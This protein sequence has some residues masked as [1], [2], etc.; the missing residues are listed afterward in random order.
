MFGFFALLLWAGSIMCFIAYALAPEDPSNLYLGI[1]LAIVVFLTGLVTFY[2]NQKSDAIMDSFKNF[3]PPKAT[4]IR[5]GEKREI[6][7]RLLV[8]GDIVLIKD[9]CKIPADV[10]IIECTEMKVD[11]SSLTGESD[12]LQ[13]SVT[14]THPDKPLETSNLAF[15]G[16]M[17]KEGTGKG[18]VIN[19][20]D[21]TVIGQIANLA[22]TAGS[23]KTPLR[24]EIDRFIFVISIIAIITGIFFFCMGFLLGYSVIT[25]LVFGIG[26]VVANV[27]EGLLATVTASLSLTAKRLSYK[28]VL[29]KNLEAVET[30]GS[31]TCICSDKT[32]T[33]TQNK[34]TVEKLWFDGSIVKGENLQVAGSS[35]VQYDPQSKGFKALQQAAISSSEAYFNR[36]VP[37]DLLE[38]L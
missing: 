15:F 26:I 1:V 35:N 2:Q 29:V 25:N 10:R 4:C 11:H 14:C 24:R 30:L 8:P 34:M 36:S 18:I 21:K 32:G 33:L 20:G 13:R 22:S 16:T 12:L 5:D 7:A 37:T 6:E 28:Y 19:T 3:I 9:Q 23:S 38:P 27:P 17:N 31:T